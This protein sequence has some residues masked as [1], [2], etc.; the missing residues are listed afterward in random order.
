MQRMERSEREGLGNMQETLEWLWVCGR[1]LRETVYWNFQGKSIKHFNGLRSV[2]WLFLAAYTRLR[3]DHWDPGFVW[4]RT[5][6]GSS[7][8]T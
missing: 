6:Y 8:K 1:T 5:R 2:E 4:V 7:G 3:L